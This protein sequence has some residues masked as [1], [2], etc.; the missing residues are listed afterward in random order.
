MY[1]KDAITQWLENEHAHCPMCNH[2]LDSIKKEVEEVNNVNPISNT[3]RRIRTS[4]IRFPRITT[5]QSNRIVNYDD[6]V[7]DRVLRTSLTDF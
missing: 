6:I 3:R 1:S 4:H 2:K 5:R 7:L